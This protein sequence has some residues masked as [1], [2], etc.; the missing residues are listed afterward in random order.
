MQE[1]FKCDLLK[2]YELFYHFSFICRPS[3]HV[4]FELNKRS[5]KSLRIFWAVCKI[6]VSFLFI[7]RAH[8]YDCSGDDNRCVINSMSPD[9]REFMISCLREDVDRFVCAGIAG[10]F[11]LPVCVE[12]M[13]P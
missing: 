1:V 9:P 7:V 11:N 10:G 4:G 3:G 5:W 13:K 2:S 6:K 8:F 12:L